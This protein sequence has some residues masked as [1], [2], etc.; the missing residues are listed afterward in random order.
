MHGLD[1][2]HPE[3]LGHGRL[4]VDVPAAHQRVKVRLPAQQRHVFLEDSLALWVIRREY[5]EHLFAAALDMVKKLPKSSTTSPAIIPM[6]SFFR[7]WRIYSSSLP[8]SL[9]A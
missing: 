5:V 8:V 1:R 6:V 2:S 4:H 7:N 3:G 9:L